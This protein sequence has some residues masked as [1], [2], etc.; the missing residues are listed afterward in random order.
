MR[1]PRWRRITR[2]RLEIFEGP[3]DLLPSPIKRDEIDVY[4]I[5]LERIT[6]Q[7]LEYLQAF[8]ELNIGERIRLAAWR[9]DLILSTL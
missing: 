2:S 5:A 4:D 9:A 1:G 7:D 8:K 6:K 3:F